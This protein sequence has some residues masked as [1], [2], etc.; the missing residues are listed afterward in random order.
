MSSNPF[1][2]DTMKIRS[3][4]F[5]VLL[6]LILSSLL[7]TSFVSIS[8]FTAAI[9]DEIRGHLE[10]NAAHLM[11]D[12]SLLASKK[13]SDAEI[14]SRLLGN[15]SVSENEI[16]DLAKALVA[17]SPNFEINPGEKGYGSI[18]VYDADGLKI[19]DVKD[20]SSFGNI[21]LGSDITNSPYYD[22][23]IRGKI[24]QDTIALYSAKNNTLID[25]M[26]VLSAPIYNSSQEVAT[27]AIEEEQQEE[28]QR[29][30]LKG[31]LILTY[32]LK[33]L[34]QQYTNFGLL[35]NK[36][37]NL[38]LLS[39]NNTI[40]YANFIG[41]DRISSYGDNNNPVDDVG[42]LGKVYP[43]QEIIHQ[44][45]ESNQSVI[46]RIYTNEI[47]DRKFEDAIFV[48]AK[49]VSPPSSP[50]V[51]GET[52]DGWNLVTSL[53]TKE[54]FREML[55]FR[56]M[57]LII[58]VVVIVISAIVVY[59]ISRKI[60][61]PLIH[62]RN[63]AT[64][65]ANGNLDIIVKHTT[66]D[67]VGELASQFERLRIN[68]KDYIENL[69]KKD[70]ELETANRSLVD[71][72]KSKDEF[73]SMVSHE[74]KT[75]IVPIKLYT[76][77]LLRSNFMGILNEKQ[78]RAV[79]IIHKSINRLEVLVNDV[80]DVY[81][82]ELGKLRLSKIDVNVVDLVREIISNLIPLTYDK[83]VTLEMDIKMVSGVL[84]CDPTRIEQVLANLIKNSIDFVSDY[85][86]KIIVRV[87]EPSTPSPQVIS[88][89]QQSIDGYPSSYFLFT[90]E[91][92]GPGIPKEKI[93][94]LFQKFYQIDTSVTRKHG[95]TGLGLVIC[96]GIVEAHGGKIW[97]DRDYA[98]GA[99][100]RFTLPYEKG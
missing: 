33:T 37:T 80:L 8:I 73:I 35:S 34:L 90:I 38:A 21:D 15:L 92:N 62:L 1:I 14:I 55:N 28:N 100:I 99:C 86:G 84:N 29:A 93:D 58:T 17:S 10:D 51:A 5:A 31:I 48:A 98:N 26:V 65:I 83:N 46:S 78:H 22:G 4:L 43:N 82:L 27:E 42:K 95:G 50:L 32:P 6:S 61:K 3:K 79:D 85:N 56:T 69:L 19:A 41:T 88:K 68:I 23:A 47:A 76:E 74:L 12:I 67:E 13:I 45:N 54:A 16:S 70:E 49:A 59:Y 81:K 52:S 40:L 44:I 63:S 64:A 75:P 72:E 96:K 94:S 2:L 9:M 89:Q 24:Y 71:A 53:S 60:S 20:S 77:M 18:S 36:N 91:D 66:N 97:I 39:N 11:N 87:E 57:F 7:V 30:P 25:F